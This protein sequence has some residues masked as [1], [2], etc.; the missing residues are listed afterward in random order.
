[1]NNQPGVDRGF[2]YPVPRIEWILDGSGSFQKALFD[3]VL[4]KLI[5]MR[6]QGR[7]CLT[8]DE[9][10]RPDGSICRKYVFWIDED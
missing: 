1:M 8:A 9:H 7:I 4:G 3:R 5:E 10:Q 6:N 2:C